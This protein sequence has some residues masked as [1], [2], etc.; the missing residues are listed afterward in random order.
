MMFAISNVSARVSSI[1]VCF[2]GP[3][4]TRA[5]GQVLAPSFRCLRGAETGYNNRSDL[6]PWSGSPFVGDDTTKAW[7]L[8]FNNTDFN[9]NNRS[10]TNT[11]R[12][13]RAGE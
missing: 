3:H 4:C 2:C 12:L 7:Q 1:T 9:V 6:S 10:N 5:C 11:V 8:N 13:V